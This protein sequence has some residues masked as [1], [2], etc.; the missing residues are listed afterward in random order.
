MQLLKDGVITPYAGGW[1][2]CPGTPCLPLGGLHAA[3]EAGARPCWCS[4]SPRACAGAP[5]LP[6]RQGGSCRRCAPPPCLLAGKR[7]PLEQVKE[8]VAV[9][10]SSA[11]GGK[12][13][14]EG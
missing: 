9:A 10:T 8:A 1:T 7:F 4:I 5:T 2:T 14:L 6:T 13:L 3:M 12:A 11:R